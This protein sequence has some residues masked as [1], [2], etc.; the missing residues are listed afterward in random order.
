MW[1][2][3]MEKEYEQAVE[4]HRIVYYED[5][6]EYKTE[7]RKECEKKLAQIRDDIKNGAIF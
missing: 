3:E 1:T 4:W 6:S 7:L 5:I 2:K